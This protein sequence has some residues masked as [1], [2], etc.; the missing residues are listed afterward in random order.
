[1][2][3]GGTVFRYASHEN[4]VLCEIHKQLAESDE[5]DRGELIA[6]IESI[7][8][9]GASSEGEWVGGR[10]MVDLLE[11]VKRYYYHPLTEGSNS[12]KKV[13][14]AVLADSEILRSK[15]SEPVYG[16]ENGIPS[17]NFEDW[18]WLP[19]G[20]TGLA[21]DPYH[22]LPSPFENLEPEEL[23]VSFFGGNELNEGGAAMTAYGKMQ[24]SEMANGERQAL[25]RALLKYCE[26]DTL[27]MVMIV[28]H[29]RSLVGDTPS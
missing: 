27:A 15:Y 8:S 22:R 20:S 25:R 4:T 18:T 28:E 2:G 9:S 10:N 6:F 12:I 29:L 7:T 13:L 17:K 3:D 19:K 1:M 11:I 5:A 21:L 23:E 24:L 16:A 14:P 26:L